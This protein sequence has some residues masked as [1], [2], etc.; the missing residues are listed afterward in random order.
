[1]FRD[2]PK[3]LSGS[4]GSA[5][6]PFPSQRTGVFCP[7]VPAS[8]RLSRRSRTVFAPF[9]PGTTCE[10]GKMTTP[11]TNSSLIRS[12]RL[13]LVHKHNKA[14]PTST[15][16]RVSERQDSSENSNC[17]FRSSILWSRIS[18]VAVL[19]H[20]LR[21]CGKITFARRPP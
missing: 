10:P 8:R 9:S 12:K 7:T 16:P 17:E 14:P 18:R 5:V 3:S 15:R 1:M 6:L 21:M 11:R 13:G 20:I 19:Q 4:N 2:H